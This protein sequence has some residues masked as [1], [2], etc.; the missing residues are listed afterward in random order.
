M[1]R[2]NRISLVLATCAL[3]AFA[4][5]RP[6]AAA[7]PEQIDA[8][9]KKG[10]AYLYK[11]QNSHGNW[12][13]VQV[14][15]GGNAGADLGQWGGRTALCTYALLAA[16]EKPLDP[17]I[18]KAT[19][20]LRGAAITG[21]YA[22]GMRANVW[23][24]LPDTPANKIALNKDSRLLKTGI[25]LSP[26]A[27]NRG[28]YD[29]QPGGNRVDLSCSQ[30]GVLGAWAVSQRLEPMPRDYW[31]VIEQAWQKVQQPDGGWNYDGAPDARHPVD[32]QMTAAGVATLFITQEF[33]HADA[34]IE[35]TKGNVTDP[36]ITKGL[37]RIAAFFPGLLAKPDMYSMYGIERVGVASGYKYIGNIDW[38][39]QG[40]DLL[41]KRQ[42]AAGHWGSEIDSCF[43]LL[44]LSRGRA[45]VMMNK[46]QYNI[47]EKDAKGVEGNW[48]QRPRDV[49]NATRWVERKVE[50]TLNWQIVNL[51]FA[52]IRD[53]HDSS[54]L[55]VSGNQ[56]LSFTD[57]EKAMLKQYV[58]EGG[59]IIGNADVGKNDFAKSFRDLAKEL[60]P[61]YEFTQLQNKGDHPL[62]SNQL[63]KMATW[64]RKPRIDAISNGARLLM[65]LIPADDFSKVLQRR[66]LSKEEVYYFIA[67]AFFYS[68]DKQQARYK[69]DTHAVRKDEKKT[70]TTTAKI[71][72]LKYSGNWDPEPGGWQR[73]G[74]VTHN[75]DNLALDVKS[76]ELGKDALDG[77]KIAHLTG[78][79]R[80]ELTDPQRDAIKKFVAAGGLLV[81]DAC[82]GVGEFDAAVQSEMTK[83]FPSEAGQITST[84]PKEFAVY[85]EK[86]EPK[87][88]VFSLTKLGADATK[89]RLRGI[90]VADKLGVLYSSEDLSTGLVG[91]HV[92]GIVG[93][94]PDVATELMRRVVK[95]KQAGKI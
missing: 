58:E 38:F 53:L 79:D 61:A 88:R 5:A 66:D 86:L 43:A 10:V 82:G 57:K 30:Y 64:K 14:A 28:F 60:F 19:E 69:G 63:S 47:T 77:Y 17:R 12:E 15:P 74:A 21:H 13:R 23:L 11:Q 56:S 40:G 41:V 92:D 84:L 44:F 62:L 48:N 7:T 59:L 42:A 31:A 55:Y 24:N 71:A 3:A 67:N 26:K 68:V 90:K 4:A 1:T 72:R 93:Y 49:A 51:N 83:I 46:L 76:V 54:M 29:Y 50:R 73:L 87:Y 34:G 75:Q 16:G 70:P 27:K 20:W 25:S 36:R 9:I 18:V 80:F 81:I 2:S 22:I 85:A 6:A 95:L 45:P 78:T 33:L 8:A 65:V 39:E 32:I 35:G 91:M 37:E 52:T 94:D 89:F